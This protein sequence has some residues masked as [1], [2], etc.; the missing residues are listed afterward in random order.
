MRSAPLWITVG[1]GLALI[2][3]GHAIAARDDLDQHYAGLPLPPATAAGAVR[4]L[5]GGR[6]AVLP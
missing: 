5:A 1:L 3:A 6:L 4:D 2:I